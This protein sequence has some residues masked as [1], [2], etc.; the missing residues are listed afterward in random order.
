MRRLL[1]SVLRARRHRQRHEAG[2]AH[3]QDHHL[4]HS[5]G[6]LRRYPAAA[7]LSLVVIRKTELLVRVCSRHCGADVLC[8]RE[9]RQTGR[10]PHLVRG[11]PL[12]AQRLRL[13]HL[14]YRVS[15]L[16]QSLRGGLRRLG[17]I[18]QRRPQTG[19]RLRI[20]RVE[21]SNQVPAHITVTT[22][23]LNCRKRNGYAQSFRRCH[24]GGKPKLQ[25]SS[26]ALGAHWKQ[27][28]A[29][30]GIRVLGDETLPLLL[31]RIGLL[32]ANGGGALPLRHTG[33]GELGGGTAGGALCPSCPLLRGGDGA[34]CQE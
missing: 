20:V 19:R 16:P 32:V 27:R 15:G 34:A 21:G 31:Q 5:G 25:G 2:P 30:A 18:A 8:R 6:A 24:T 28:H 13:L 4:S 33:F 26:A 12:A 22:R 14:R 17:V 11:Q 7:Q 10:K 1:L 29:E 23:L 3:I 9:T